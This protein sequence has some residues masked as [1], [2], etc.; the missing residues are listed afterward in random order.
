LIL[1]DDHYLLRALLGAAPPSIAHEPIVTTTSWWWR[2][3]SPL[4]AARGVPGVHSRLAAGLSQAE[5][6]ALWQALCQV[7][8]QGSLITMHELVSLG[9]AM[10]W[11][12][13]VE[14][15]NRLAA[16]AVAAAKDL[17]ATIWVRTGNEGR[18][19]ELSERY[20]FDV[21]VAP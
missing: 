8:Q 4:A 13:R 5:A 16:E 19:V 17:Q 3:L 14:G 2:A 12:A 11:L 10:A 18:L 20:G 7:G 15:L 6:D 1:V 9:P 21:I